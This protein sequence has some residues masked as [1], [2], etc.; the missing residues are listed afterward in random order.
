MSKLQIFLTAVLALF[1]FESAYVIYTMGYVGFFEAALANPATSLMAFDLVICLTIFAVWMVR[2][3]RE[4]GRSPLGY[5]LLTATFG[6]AGPLLYLIR[7]SADRAGERSS[8]A[9]APK[10]A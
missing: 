1:L 7:H 8:K 4:R 3:A 6:S 10:A 9:P 2:D 5:L